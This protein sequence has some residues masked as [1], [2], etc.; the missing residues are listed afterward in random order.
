LALK[1]PDGRQ[2]RGRFFPR[3]KAKSI[4]A[5]VS[6][7]REVECACDSSQSTDNGEHDK[8]PAERV[9]YLVFSQQNA[10]IERP[11]VSPSFSLVHNQCLLC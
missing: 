7:W 9:Q 1:G 4:G 8:T 5:F 3:P 11:P 6:Y 2:K 10:G